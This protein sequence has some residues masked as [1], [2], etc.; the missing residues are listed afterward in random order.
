[1]AQPSAL[2][3][4]PN[5]C[6][7]R[8]PFFVRPRGAGWARHFLAIALS[9]LVRPRRSHLACPCLRGAFSEKRPN[10]TRP[11]LPIFRTFFPARWH[12]YPF[13]T[14][15]HGFRRGRRSFRCYTPCRV[16]SGAFP[17]YL[18]SAFR[19]SNPFFPHRS[20]TKTIFCE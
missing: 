20:C 1:M 2:G 18:R 15:S 8:F 17:R 19:F 14:P 5:L 3:T 13:G 16:L 6:D 4:F 11:A 12:R 9:V 10:P 7:H